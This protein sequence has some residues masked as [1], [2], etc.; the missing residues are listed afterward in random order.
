MNNR[1][2]IDPDIQHGKPVIKGTRIPVTR[3]IGE[4]AGGMTKEEIMLEYEVTEEDIRA[5]LT[6]ASELIENEEFH[7]LPE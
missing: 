6:Y 5:A 4:L 3:I 2:I 7:P 1:I